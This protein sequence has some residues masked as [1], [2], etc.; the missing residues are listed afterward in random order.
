MNDH[1]PHHHRT[2]PPAALA[3]FDVLPA[4]MQARAIREL[5]RSGWF[6]DDAARVAGLT[7][8]DLLQLLTAFPERI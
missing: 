7:V 1:R 2:T 5:I 4:E 6:V 8:D 3:A